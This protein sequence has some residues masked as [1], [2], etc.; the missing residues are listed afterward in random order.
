MI[1]TIISICLGIGLAAS[2]GFRV[3][4]PLFVLS[5][6]THY[7]YVPVS[8]SFTWIGSQAAMICLGGAIQ[9]Q[10]HVDEKASGPIL[11]TQDLINSE[12]V[13]VAVTG[14]TDGELVRGVRYTPFGAISHSIVMRGKSR[15]VREIRTEHNLR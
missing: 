8:E 12:D 9:G 10:L 1:E 4:V 3:F 13:F 5:L 14:I 7:G 11:H 15:T 6:A 2:A